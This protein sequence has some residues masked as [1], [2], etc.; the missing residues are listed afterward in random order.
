MHMVRL[1]KAEDTDLQRYW[2]GEGG[3][4]KWEEE[5]NHTSKGKVQGEEFTSK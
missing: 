2:G 4:A 5:C 1:G 3:R